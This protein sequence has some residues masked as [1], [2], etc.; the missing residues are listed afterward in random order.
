MSTGIP[1]ELITQQIFQEILD[2]DSVR[3]IQV[4]QNIT[5]QGKSAT[6]QI[7]VFWDFETG[8]IC[9]ATVVQAKDWSTPVNQGELLKF[10]AVLDDLPGQPRG[11]VVTRS[12]YQSGA[13][14]FAHA[15]G[16]LLYELTE[17]PDPPSPPIVLTD[18]SWAKIRLIGV[19]P[20]MRLLSEITVFTPEFSDA[21]FICDQEWLKEIEVRFGSEVVKELLSTR[22]SKPPQDVALYAEDGKQTGT[23]RDL[24]MKLVKEM[25]EAEIANRHVNIPFELPV[26][27]RTS[28]APVPLVKLASLSVTISIHQTMEQQV[29]RSGF[30]EFVLK[31]LKD[32]TLKHFRRQRKIGENDKLHK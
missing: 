29:M 21:T 7:D 12:G 17:T 30:V 31:N 10:K 28:V 14:E 2:Q 18:V 26:L 5:L 1:Y 15:H 25:R 3:T 8:G 4:K 9:Y 16:I 20:D 32:G 24:Y 27:M 13:R 6:H 22:F 23:L 19:T 11:I